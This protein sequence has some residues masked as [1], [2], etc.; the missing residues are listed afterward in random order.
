M[1]LTVRHS[2]R[3]RI[4]PHRLIEVRSATHNARQRVYGGKSLLRP[5]QWSQTVP[6]V[7]TIDILQPP[8][9]ATSQ[10]ENPGRLR[11][12]FFTDGCYVHWN[13]SEPMMKLFP[14]RERCEARLTEFFGARYWSPR[15]VVGFLGPLMDAMYS[16]TGQSQ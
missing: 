10:E 16:R 5:Y 15:P 7:S 2:Y 3:S 4:R 13:R 12:E 9:G 14:W 8:A 11:T 6:M 1:L